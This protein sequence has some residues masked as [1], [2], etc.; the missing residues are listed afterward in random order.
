MTKRIWLCGV[1]NEENSFNNSI[2]SRFRLLEKIH[3]EFQ[4]I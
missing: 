4:E 3:G 1:F 2:D